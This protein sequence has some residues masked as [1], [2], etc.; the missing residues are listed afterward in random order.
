MSLQ[1]IFTANKVFGE[2]PKVNCFGLPGC[3][4]GD[5]DNPSDPNIQDNVAAVFTGNL[6]SDLI[7]YV[8][9]I[10]VIALMGSGIMYLLSSGEE[11]QTNRAKKW[12]IWSLVG[13]I[14]SISAY[15]IVGLL[16]TFQI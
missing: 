4:D 3:V 7:Q 2:A 8:A 9:V 16:N 14:L 15:G 6:I 5:I 13:V 1:S 11:E 12:I 10:A